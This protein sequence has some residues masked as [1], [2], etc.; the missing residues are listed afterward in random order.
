[1]WG[2][3][4]RGVWGEERWMRLVVGRR[5]HEVWGVQAKLDKDVV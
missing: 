4:M 1:M 2:E 3:V 5:D